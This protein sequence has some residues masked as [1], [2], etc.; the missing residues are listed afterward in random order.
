MTSAIRS[1]GPNDLHREITSCNPKRIFG[2][3][4]SSVSEPEIPESEVLEHRT[5]PDLAEEKHRGQEE[6][7]WQPRVQSWERIRQLQA[8]WLLREA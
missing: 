6:R 7:V 4:F 2:T 8:H 1:H 3:S 5:V